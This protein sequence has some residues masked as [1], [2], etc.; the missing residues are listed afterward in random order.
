MQCFA[1]ALLLLMSD[2]DVTW[3]MHECGISGE[4][5]Q[6]CRRSR[7]TTAHQTSMDNPDGLCAVPTH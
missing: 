2:Y 5:I 4:A 1:P 6:N 3:K 7:M